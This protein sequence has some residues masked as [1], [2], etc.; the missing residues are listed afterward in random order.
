MRNV[1]SAAISRPRK[2]TE[3]SRADEADDRLESGRLSRAVAAKQ[4]HDRALAHEEG[5]ATENLR[6]A[7]ARPEAL[8]R[9]LRAHDEPPSR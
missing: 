9:Q 8:D 7:V 3:P 6:R 5:H 1:S 2:R 4:R